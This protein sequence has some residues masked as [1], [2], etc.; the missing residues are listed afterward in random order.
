LSNE[1]YFKKNQSE[2]DCTF[3]FADV[4]I[5]RNKIVYTDFNSSDIIREALSQK[6]KSTKLIEFS[7]QFPDEAT[8]KIVYRR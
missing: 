3:D 7:I 4:Y 2:K 8:P 1:T 5:Q 6:I